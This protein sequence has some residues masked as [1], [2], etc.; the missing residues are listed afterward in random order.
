M[1]LRPF[2]VVTLAISSQFIKASYPIPK[3][4]KEL[5]V[6]GMIMSLSVQVPIPTTA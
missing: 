4:G 1:Y 6:Y 5:Y 2:D 3:T